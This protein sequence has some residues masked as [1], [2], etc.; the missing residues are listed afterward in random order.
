MPIFDRS[1]S[2]LTVFLLV[3]VSTFPLWGQSQANTGTIGG[4]VTDAPG[5]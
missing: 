5:G 1:L 4:T 2:W 3:L